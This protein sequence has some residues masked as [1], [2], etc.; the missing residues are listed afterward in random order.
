M[1]Q[2]VQ[3]VLFRKS[4]WT[5]VRARVWLRGHNFRSDKVDTTEDFHRFRQFDPAQC[6]GGF[7]TLTE[8]FPEGVRA[9]SCEVFGQ[10][11][12]TPHGVRWSP[13]MRIRDLPPRGCVEA[14]EEYLDSIKVVKV[15]ME[16]QITIRTST[17]G[18]HTHTVRIVRSGNVVRSSVTNEH[19][20]TF[21]ISRNP[22]ATV[23]GSV[24][25]GHRHIVRIPQE[26]RS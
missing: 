11:M 21:N 22:A 16:K 1:A 17:A 12:A 9:V 6:R 18:G 7:R 19:S 2:K 3:T 10:R 4:N 14:L 23:P 24:V 20:H 13:G 8:N 26:F 25:N 15:L 5:V